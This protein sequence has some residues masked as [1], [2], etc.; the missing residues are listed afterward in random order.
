MRALELPA[1]EGGARRRIRH[2]LAAHDLDGQGGGG[3]KRRDPLELGDGLA[4]VGFGAGPEMS[5]DLLKEAVLGMRLSAWS[6]AGAG[7]RS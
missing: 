6:W 5:G 2:R 1:K 7:R 4:V 3:G